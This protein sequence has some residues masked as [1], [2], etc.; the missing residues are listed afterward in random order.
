MVDQDFGRQN[1]LMSRPTLESTTLGKKTTNGTTSPIDS[2]PVRTKTPEPTPLT[3]PT[4]FPEQNRKAHVPGN[5]DPCMSFECMSFEC[6]SF[7]CIAS[8]ACPSNG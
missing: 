3:L 2:I 7:E 6:M 5:L 1:D 8:S 4:E